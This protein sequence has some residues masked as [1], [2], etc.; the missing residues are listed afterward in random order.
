MKT[1]VFFNNKGGVGKTSLVYH[2]AWMYAELGLP[3]VAADLDP[4]SNL[5]SM[6]LDED[7]LL[8]LWPDEEHTHTVLGA[9]Q[10]IM[11]GIGDISKPHVEEIDRNIGLVVGDLGVSMFEDELSAQW[12]DCLDRK[13]RAFRVISAFFRLLQY[14]GES[15][16]AELA[17]IDVG[18]NLGAINRA[19]MIAADFV[20]IPLAPDLFSLQ[21]LRNVGPTLIRWRGEWEER[22]KRNPEP[23]L[24]L[25]RGKMKP[26]GY[27]VHQHATRQDRPVKAYARWANR[28]PLEYRERVLACEEENPPVIEKDPHCLALIKHYRS[29]MPM[30]MEAR[31]PIF[32]L[33]PADGAIGAHV[34]AVAQCKTDYK[35]LAQRILDC[36]E[37]E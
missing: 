6:F 24:Q 25:P 35:D 8:D 34:N 13:E 26:I 1:I 10:P 16:D 18:P 19:A 14:A 29:L 28:I 30:A 37:F 2:L 17:L 3:V 32:A 11:K 21:G 31:K 12:P 7:R 5:T 23:N 33:K 36:I 27:I 4:Q 20:V 9:I 22:L 15:M